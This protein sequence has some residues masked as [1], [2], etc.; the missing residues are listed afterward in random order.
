M[1]KEKENNITPP[2]SEVLPVNY[3]GLEYVSWLIA[4]SQNVQNFANTIFR[5]GFVKT[6]TSYQELLIA[7]FKAIKETESDIEQIKSCLENN[8]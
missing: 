7:L 3:S 6:D 8:N 1:T 5:G 2:V 4:D